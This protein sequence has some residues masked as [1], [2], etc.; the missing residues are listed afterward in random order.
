MGW[1]FQGLFQSRRFWVAVAGVL[2]VVCQDMGLPVS[3]DQVQMLVLLLAGWIVGD[4]IRA[5]TPVLVGMLMIAGL[6]NAGYCE[7]PHDLCRAATVRI[8]NGSSLGSG[9][10]FRDSDSSLYILTNAHVAGTRLGNP[11]T[12]EFWIRGHQSHPIPGI[13]VAVSYVPGGY[14]DIAVVRIDRSQLQ[15]FRP[16]V[17]PLADPNQPA[18][19]DALYSVGCPS[20]RW[21]TAFE[22]FSLRREQS[23]GDT[24]HFVPMPAGGRSGSAIFDVLGKAPRIVGLIAWRSS[25]EGGHGLDGRGEGH[26]FGIAMT[27]HEVWAG[28]RGQEQPSSQQLLP[29][30]GMVQTQYV[31]P[32]PA[33]PRAPPSGTKGAGEPIRDSPRKDIPATGRENDV[34]LLYSDPVA[35][36]PNPTPPQTMDGDCPGGQC[37][38]SPVPPQDGRLFPSLPPFLQQPLVPLVP[39]PPQSPTQFWQQPWFP[40][41]LASALLVLLNWHRLTGLPNKTLDA[42]ADRLDQRRQPPSQLRS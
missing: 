26:G 20:G 28:L 37:P 6:C 17:I 33:A 22:G 12:C 29:P 5:A 2:L 9:T 42:L 25:E 7:D 16:P 23:A 15:G 8:R 21:P 13:T 35:V 41:A 24:I 30:R 31:Q 1:K 34:I 4:S 39:A 18:S 27:H 19:Y 32:S 38:P 36:G 14:R 11:V 3:P 10:V 40:W